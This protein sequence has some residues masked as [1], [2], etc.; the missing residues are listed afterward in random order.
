MS[1]NPQRDPAAGEACGTSGSGCRPC[2][3]GKF[4]L[5]LLAGLAVVYILANRPTGPAAPSAVDW[6]TDHDQA[7]AL[8]SEQNQ[9]VLLAFKATWCGPCRTMDNEVFAKQAAAD[10]LSGW[11]PVSVDVDE[12]QRVAARYDVSGIPAFVALS[13]SG[14]EIGRAAGV[15]S[16]AEFAQFIASAEARTRALAT[17]TAQVH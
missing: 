8:A 16:L 17:P 6:I 10:A 4:L 14:Q 15:M 11:V 1:D 7:L 13:P 2:G 9:P 3:S 12:Q 5:L